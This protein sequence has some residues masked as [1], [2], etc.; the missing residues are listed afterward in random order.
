[1]TETPSPHLP[2][3]TLAAWLSPGFPVGAFAYSHGLEQAIAAGEVTDAATAQAW[4][5]T[6]ALHGAGRNDAILT[7][8]AMRGEDA[9]E[10]DALARAFAASEERLRETAAMGAAFGETV[11]AAWSLPA[12]H[13]GKPRTYP[14]ALGVAARGMEPGA[15]V[16]M[17]L[18]A[19]AANLVSAAVRL[20][21]LGQVEGQR[22]LAALH[23]LVARVAAEACEATTDEMGGCAWNAD[24]AA[25]RH[26]TQTVR[27]FRT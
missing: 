14:V 19:F 17:A 5:G 22:I 6:C 20:V 23:P 18:S 13:D 9:D 3:L 25:M 10:L 4:I 12:G 26:E 11:A 24:I 27:L 15:V 16:A 2:L 8:A 7:A 1:M 21:P